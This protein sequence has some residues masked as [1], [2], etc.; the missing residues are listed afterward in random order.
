MKESKIHKTIKTL[1]ENGICV[2]VK[3]LE[4]YKSFVITTETI[5]HRRKGDQLTTKRQESRKRSSEKKK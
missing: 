2:D 5:E 4:D 3:Y 1:L